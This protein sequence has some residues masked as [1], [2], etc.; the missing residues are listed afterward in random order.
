MNAT[1]I[2]Y[3]DFTWS[4]LVGCSGLGCAAFNVCWAKYM[5]KRKL[6]D[7]QP[8]YEFKPHVHFERLEQPFHVK[9]P[10][11][12][13]VCYSA[14]FWDNG[15][16]WTDRARVFN[17]TDHAKWHWFINLTKQTQNIPTKDAEA[18]I[19]GSNWIQGASICTEAD[20]YRVND[21]VKLKE[22]GWAKFLALSIEP[23][24]AKIPNLNLS[25]IDWVIIGGQTHPTKLPEKAWVDEIITKARAKDIPVFI[26]NNLD[27]LG[28]SAHEYPK[29]LSLTLSGRESK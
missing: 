9:A 27:I 19:L 12:I 24:Y 18:F 25:G 15:F 23:L 2:E 5:K 10:K 29:A 14:D 20:L 8:C 21:L 6:T 4:P 7:C 26:K 22:K 17:V 1:G 3:L 13:G 28:Y 16:S 11:L